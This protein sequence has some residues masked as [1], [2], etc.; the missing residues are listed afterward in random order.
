MPLAYKVLF[1][2]ASTSGNE[3]CDHSQALVKVL[4]KYIGLACRLAEEALKN[5]VKM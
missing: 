2:E 4:K 5:L 3:T 1:S